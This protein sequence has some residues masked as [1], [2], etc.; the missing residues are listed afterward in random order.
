MVNY[1]VDDLDA[2]LERLQKEGVKIDPNLQD[3]V[4]ITRCR[5]QIPRQGVIRPR[6]LQ[7]IA[8][9]VTEL[10]AA[11]DADEIVV[12]TRDQKNLLK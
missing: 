5:K 2:L 11:Q 8:Q 3:E 6:V 9:I 4:R 7:K 12:V 1:M 10:R